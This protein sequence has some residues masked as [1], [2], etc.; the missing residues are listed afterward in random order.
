VKRSRL[1]QNPRA[2]SGM[3]TRRQPLSKASPAQRDKVAAM[4][5][6]SACPN[7]APFVPI[8]PAH[9]A[10]KGYRGGCDDPDC[11]VALCRFC[12]GSFDRRQL[13]LST[14]VSGP[15]FVPELQHML[16]H[17][18]GDWVAMGERLSGLKVLVVE[19]ER[20]E[21]LGG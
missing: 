1:H 3:S 18:D 14:V 21:G 6:C 7:V 19:H 5:R 4:T 11:V 17:Y 12:H 16:A 10:A 8:D 2:R 13:D 9:L 20:A 15:A